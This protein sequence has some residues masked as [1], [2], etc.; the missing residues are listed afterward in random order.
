[1]SNPYTILGLD[2]SVSMDDIQDRF[3]DLIKIYRKDKT[4]Y[5]TILNA[6]NTIVNNRKNRVQQDPAMFSDLKN[7]YVQQS[8]T[9]QPPPP[10]NDKKFDINE[11]NKNFQ[12][13][14]DPREFKTRDEILS[15]RKRIDEELDQTKPIFKHSE[16]FDNDTFQKLYDHFNKPKNTGEITPFK[17]LDVASGSFA[18][19]YT[20]INSDKT[21]GRDISNPYQPITDVTT[22]IPKEIDQHLIKQIK[23]QPRASIE[24][25]DEDRRRMVS[26]VTE[27]KGTSFAPPAGSQL[28]KQVSLHEIKKM[29]DSDTSQQMNSV[30]RQRSVKSGIEQPRQELP[31]SN[32]ELLQQLE[33]LKKTLDSQSK[34]INQLIKKN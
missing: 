10:S 3:N 12:A 7:K 25:T 24:T 15:E 16:K 31:N 28:P 18:E 19:A 6:Y 1:M 11:F 20:F 30:L 8:D 23:Q 2:E 17:D 32:T 27:Y 5:S 9:Y 21:S 22:S 29:S 26:K 14:S 33:E 34:I 4:Q 13:K